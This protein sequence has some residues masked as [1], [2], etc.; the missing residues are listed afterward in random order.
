MSRAVLPLVAVALLAAAPSATSMRFAGHWE[1][2]RGRSDGRFGGAS[3]RSFHAGDV[4]EVRFPGTGFRVYG[5]TGPTGGHAMVVVANRPDHTIDFYAPAKHTH[6]LLDTVSGLMPGE[7]EA[8]VIVVPAR[9]PSSRGN[10]VNIDAVD[11]IP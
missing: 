9:D 1:V 2:V 7:H 10:Y 5:V 6:V 4:L 8:A 11:V 3:A